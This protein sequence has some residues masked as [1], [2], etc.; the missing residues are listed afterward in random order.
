M[1]LPPLPVAHHI[2]NA[3][4]D[5]NFEFLEQIIYSN[6][7]AVNTVGPAGYNAMHVAAAKSDVAMIELLLK[8]GADRSLLAVDGDSCNHI[9]CRIGNPELLKYFLDCTIDDIEIDMKNNQGQT[10]QDICEVVP[11][12]KEAF[13]AV[14]S[15][16]VWDSKDPE[17]NKELLPGLL[18]GRKACRDIIIEERHRRYHNRRRHLVTTFI[19]NAEDRQLSQ[20]VFR[21]AGTADERRFFVEQEMPGP[22][23]AQPWSKDDEVF[24]N[25]HRDDLMEGTI[26]S[27]ALDIVSRSVETAFQLRTQDL[28]GKPFSRAFGI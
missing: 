16:R 14:F 25:S 20:K 23:N 11:T 22:Y 24:F 1:N 6:R 10:M 7:E 12:E 26:V 17:M 3:V 27:F 8:Y 2:P 5:G 4:I 9:A 19:G 21:N 15:F 13:D 28:T 18:A